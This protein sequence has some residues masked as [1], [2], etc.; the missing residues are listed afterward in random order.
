MKK[1]N[2]LASLLLALAMCI[3][4]AVP[5]LAYGED[6]PSDEEVQFIPMSRE[7]YIASKAAGENISY[8]E[9]EADVDSKIA[10]AI[11]AIP[12]TQAWSPDTTVDNHD[13]TYTS[14]GRI[15]KIYT[16][17]SGL[18]MR[19]SVEA[20]KLRST[21]GAN[22]IDLNTS[23]A[24]C[25]PDGSGN[26]NFIGTTSANLLSNTQIRLAVTGYF[27]ISESLAASSS[28]NLE[29]FAYSV[30]VGKTVYYR[31]NVSDVH[32]ERA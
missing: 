32:I 31:D 18:S 8:E 13:T 7:A 29:L 20:V 5:A 6:A 19:Y 1:M 15:Y 28:I 2:K 22:W 11:A 30:T 16:H 4:L 23:S 26:H 24:W 21:Q 10:A 14:Y 9:A 27:E 17:A 12:S 25:Q 3:A